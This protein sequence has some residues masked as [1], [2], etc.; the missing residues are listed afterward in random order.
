MARKKAANKSSQNSR[1]W[2]GKYSRS[3][4]E[5]VAKREIKERFLIVCEGTKTEP[6]YFQSFPVPKDV[7]DVRGC[8]RNTISLVK[9]AVRIIQEEDN[10]YEQVWSVFDRDSFPVKNFNE[11]IKYAEDNDIKVAYSNEAFELWYLL[12]FD[13]RHTAMSRTEYK[14]ALT[15]KMKNLTKNKQKKYKKNSDEMYEILASKQHQAI[16]N[17]EKLLKQYNPP[18]PANDNPSTT[19]HLL[20]KQLNR[21]VRK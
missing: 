16:Q 2:K 9:E 4:N 3:R 19:V 21:F 10:D 6:I 5:K 11:A 12:H 7:I 14:K 18:E 15:E 17:A 1:N 8:G 20:V 13:Y